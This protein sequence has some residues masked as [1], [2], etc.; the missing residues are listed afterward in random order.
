VP[1]QGQ[2]WVSQLAFA[3]D[4]SSLL[5]RTGARR[6]LHWRIEADTRPVAVLLQD[7]QLLDKGRVAGDA[8]D[9]RR[10]LRVRDR[11]P[12]PALE[13]ALPLAVAR[14]IE[15]VPLPARSTS[16]GPLQLDLSAVYNVAADGERDV[17]TNAVSSMAVYP[18]GL[19]RLRGIDFDI[20]GAVQ[21]HQADMSSN[22]NYYSPRV[23]AGVAVPAIPVA[24]LHALIYAP[25][26]DPVTTELDYAY[27]RLHYRDGSEARIAIRTGRDVPGYS[28]EHEQSPMAWADTRIRRLR[29]WGA[30]A[31]LA[32]PRLVNPYP[33]RLIASVDLEALAVSTE[34]DPS[35]SAPLS[36]PVFFAITVEPALD[37]NQEIRE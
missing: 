12:W 20:R 17:A 10:R 37:P 23:A 33:D 11:G 36:A 15:Q 35:Y 29:G 25:Q 27:L 32:A 13:P 14:T 19:Q 9:L 16:T 3:A 4:G 21:L 5:A 6:F 30:A 7:A 18:V 26:Q 8:P 28:A 31:V 34:R 24:A 22:W 2:D 1:A